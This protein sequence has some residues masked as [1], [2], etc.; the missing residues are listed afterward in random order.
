MGILLEDQ[1]MCILHYGDDQVVMVQ[2]REDIEYMTR[3]L[4]E[5][6]REWSLEI[7]TTK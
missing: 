3:K 4:V 7:M 5:K 2:A 1:K 6:Y